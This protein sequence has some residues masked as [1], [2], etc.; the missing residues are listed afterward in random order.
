MSPGANGRQYQ[1]DTTLQ[2][3]RPSILLIKKN[4]HNRVGSSESRDSTEKR[5]EALRHRTDMAHGV[6][7]A[8]CGNK[9]SSVGA[10]AAT[11]E[12]PATR[13]ALCPPLPSS[14]RGS[15]SGPDDGT[16]VHDTM[17]VR[18]QH[19]N[20]RQHQTVVDKGSNGKS[21]L[22]MPRTQQ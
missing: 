12:L 10:N 17:H 6:T 9:H 7:K 14:C 20:G 1:Y 5:H 21:K 2:S 3:R 16:I 15:H 11:R 18:Q 22:H 8:Y 19:T 4:V 13:A